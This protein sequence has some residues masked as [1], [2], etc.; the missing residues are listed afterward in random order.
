MSFVTCWVLQE[1]ERTKKAEEE[2]EREELER[3]AKRPRHH[4]L[5]LITLAAGS[6]EDSS[7]LVA[8]LEKIP[9]APKR[10]AQTDAFVFDD[11]KA[12]K[13]QAAVNSL[14]EKLQNLKV[15]ARAKVTENRIYSAAYHPDV[16]KDLVFFGGRHEL[17]EKNTGWRD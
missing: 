3:L 12:T 10:I 15:A 17:R 8:M 14:R 6:A 2:L 9:L 5:D 7:S 13:E 16:T 1:E 11:H 4:D